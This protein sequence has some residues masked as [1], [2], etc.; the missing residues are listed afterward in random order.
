MRE[1]LRDHDLARLGLIV[2][3]GF[4]I[5][6]RFAPADPGELAQA[7]AASQEVQGGDPLQALQWLQRMTRVRP[8]AASL[9]DA[10]LYA[11]A[12]NGTDLLNLQVGQLP[13]QTGDRWIGLP[14]AENRQP[15]C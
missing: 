9:A 12:L 2:G 4:P 13:F 15:E 8:G 1:I 14:F 7:F 6:P 11:D 10:F 3:P 5:L